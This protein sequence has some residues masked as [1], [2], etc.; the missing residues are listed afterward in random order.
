MTNHITRDEAVKIEM[1]KPSTENQVSRYLKH[2]LF[3]VENGYEFTATQV[4][5]VDELWQSV[6]GNDD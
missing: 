3:W 4:T 6:K 5:A 1:D 2:R